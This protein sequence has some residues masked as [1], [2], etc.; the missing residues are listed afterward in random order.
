MRLVDKHY[1]LFSGNKIK[2]SYS[3]V[4]SM[5][6]VIQK[7][8]SKIIKDPAPSTIKTCNFRRKTDCPKDSNCLSE[9]LIYKTSVNTTTNKYYYGA[10]ES[11]FKERY[12]SYECSFRNK[13]YEKNTELSKY[14]WVLFH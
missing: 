6:N 10:C 7:H 4:L 11:T 12:K 14:V 13:S 3:C 2:L 9:C 8:N 1:K 5:N